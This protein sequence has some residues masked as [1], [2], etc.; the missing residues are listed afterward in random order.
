[1]HILVAQIGAR[2]HYAVPAAF[3]AAGLL[4]RLETTACAH[5]PLVRTASLLPY[6]MQPNGLRRLA[7]RRVPGVDPRKISTSLV[8]EARNFFRRRKKGCDNRY[9][10]FA[11]QNR[12][13][14]QHVCRR[15][16]EGATAVYAFNAAAI[17]IFQSAKSQGLNCILDQ[18]MA[19]FGF[20]EPLLE[21]ERQRWPGWE[22]SI[23][24]ESWQP[25]FEREIR[26][27]EL[28]DVIICGSPFVMETIG[29]CGGPVEKCRV[30]RYG[31]PSNIDVSHDWGSRSKKSPLAP[32]H[33]LFAGTLCLRKGLQYVLEAARE[34]KEERVHFRAVGPIEIGERALRDVTEV[35]EVTGAVRRHEMQ[36]HYDWADVL[37]IPSLA[38]GSANVAL[39]AM[40]RGVPVI[41]THNAGTLV[42]ETLSGTIIPCRSGN[43]ISQTISRYNC[44]RSRI[45]RQSYHARQASEKATL[46]QYATVLTQTA[47]F[48]TLK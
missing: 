4:E 12:L 15:G 31:H 25:L 13:F 8:F 14:G 44:D 36:Q 40:S 18:T 19:P 20:V 45:G 43:I 9:E 3:A 2:R 33:V 37:L 5:H 17:E 47:A 35:I 23:P 48:L 41:A 38:E 28:A 26:E 10:E 16:F 7:E 27:W 32:L 11:I 22:N 46:Q 42:E 1:M 34:L 24:N 39:E 21:E 30:V 6:R 29:E